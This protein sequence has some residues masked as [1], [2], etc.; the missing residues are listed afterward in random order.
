MRSA[1][2]GL[3]ALCAIGCGQSFD[4]TYSGT[5]TATGS[6]SD[7]SGIPTQSITASWRIRDEGG[8]LDINTSGTCDPLTATPSSNGMS[9]SINQ[10][11]CPQYSNA[12]LTFAPRVTGGTLSLDG[13]K[14]SVSLIMKADVSGE[15]SG[16]CDSTMSGTL[17]R[18]DE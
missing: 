4:G 3:M 1:L 6:C 2:L 14:L 15:A 17:T 8:S 9:A 13:D 18:K 5:L 12:G 11:A 16:F 7:G 10:K